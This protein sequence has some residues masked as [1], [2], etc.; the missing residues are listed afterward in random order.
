MCQAW[1][2]LLDANT[3]AVSLDITPLLTACLTLRFPT[4]VTS[5]TAANLR[6]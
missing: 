2:S 6:E 4:R 1:F 3:F 5:F